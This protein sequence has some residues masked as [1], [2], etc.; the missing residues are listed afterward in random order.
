MC[1]ARAAIT[2]ADR[3]DA[4]LTPTLAE[5]DGLPVGVQLFG[6]PAAEGALL[7]LAAQLEEARPWADRRPPL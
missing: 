2:W 6:R 4:V 3:Y 1:R 5:R 7:G